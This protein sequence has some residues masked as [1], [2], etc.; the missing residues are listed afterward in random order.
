MNARVAKHKKHATAIS[1]L[2]IPLGDAANFF[3]SDSMNLC[4]SSGSSRDSS[5]IKAPLGFG[6]EEDEIVVC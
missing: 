3:N 2:Y 5:S 4:S 1:R 6:E